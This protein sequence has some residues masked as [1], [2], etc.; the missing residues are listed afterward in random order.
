MVLRQYRDA[1]QAMA[2]RMAL[3]A[4]GIECYLYDENLVRMDWFWSNLIGG[5][6]VVVREKDAKD[7]AK[8]LHERFPD[9]MEH[10]AGI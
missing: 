2:D 3:E 9:E 1:P 6:K 10:G 7:A 5:V 8:V 4:A